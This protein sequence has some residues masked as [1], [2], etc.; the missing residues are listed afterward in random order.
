MPPRLPAGG[1][2]R[3]ALLAGVVALAMGAC[4]RRGAPEP[5]PDPNA[6]PAPS[7][8]GTGSQGTGTPSARSRSA[9]VS[10]QGE[11]EP[12]STALANRSQALVQ[13]TPEDEVEPAEDENFGASPQPVP[14]SR[15]RKNYVVPKEPFIL[16]PLL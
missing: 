4:G 16:D 12:S 6:R 1:A 3:L 11:S 10:P 9:A 5:P 2:L 8:Q 7:R 15:R 13:N 14:T